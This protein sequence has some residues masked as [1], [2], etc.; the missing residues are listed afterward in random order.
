MIIDGEGCEVD[1]HFLETPNYSK[2]SGD[3]LDPYV[4]QVNKHQSTEVKAKLR[5]KDEI[6]QIHRMGVDKLRA[7]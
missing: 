3:T 5:D 7:V 4:F 6:F 1:E 2:F